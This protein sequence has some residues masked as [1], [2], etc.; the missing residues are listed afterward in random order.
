MDTSRHMSSILEIRP[1]EGRA[2]V[3]PGVIRDTLNRE[4]AVHGLQFG[5]D[6]S[7]TNRCML[8][9]MI[10][11]NSAGSFSLKHRTTREHVQTMRVVLSD[12]SLAEFGPLTNEELEAKK[13][14]QNTGRPHLPGNAGIA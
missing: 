12:G 11:N 1:A 2:T 13:T 14:T 7:T 3:Q 4:A 6:T 10:G 9:G 8:G 5:P